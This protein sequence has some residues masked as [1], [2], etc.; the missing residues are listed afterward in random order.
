MKQVIVDIIKEGWK[1]NLSVMQVLSNITSA[2]G[3]KQRYALDQF[4]ELVLTCKPE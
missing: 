3:L 1:K 2:T 4:C